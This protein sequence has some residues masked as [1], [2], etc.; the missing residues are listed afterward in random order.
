MQHVWTKWNGNPPAPD[1]KVI[2][3]WDDPPEKP[4]ALQATGR[5]CKRGGCCFWADFG[6]SMTPPIWWRA[7][8]NGGPDATR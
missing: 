3:S 7:E 5:S 4:G 1:L 2:G 6:E 8:S